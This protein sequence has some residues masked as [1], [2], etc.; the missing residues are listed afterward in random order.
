MRQWIVHEARTKGRPAHSIADTLADSDTH[1]NT[2]SNANTYAYIVADSDTH[3][4]SAGQRTSHD[5]RAD[6]K[7]KEG[8][9]SQTY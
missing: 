9:R 8:K 7:V 2:H 6:D 1:S 3:R 5:T 4:H